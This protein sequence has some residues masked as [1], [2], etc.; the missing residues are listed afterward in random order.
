[1]SSLVLY[2]RELI[3]REAK[4]K[5]ELDVTV[6]S[7]MEANK[8]FQQYAASIEQRS[9]QKE[10]NRITRELHDGLGYI[11]TNLK[12]MMDAAEVFI[13]R[14]QP[15]ELRKLLKKASDQA[16]QGLEETRK[17]LHVLRTSES[18][19]E[20][21]RRIQN[22]IDV[23]KKA[24]GI[25]IRTHYGNIPWSF[26]SRIDGT[27]FRLVQEGM[28]NSFRHGKATRIDLKFWQTN[29]EFQIHIR[30]NGRGA[31]EVE[32]GIGMLGMKERL[33]QLGG[34]MIAHNV[35]GGFELSVTIPFEMSISYE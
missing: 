25:D 23:F 15:D 26:G 4:E 30:D 29:S 33:E 10:R 31:A 19:I 20:G 16:D 22:M 11:F 35:D 6:K 21:L 32:E 14:N 34:Q 17:S 7:L 12:M 5:D 3:V 27:V 1:M 18:H 13:R 2:Y 24:T 8:G 9:L 28:I